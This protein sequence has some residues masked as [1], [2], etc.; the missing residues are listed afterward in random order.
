VASTFSS[1]YNVAHFVCYS[2]SNSVVVHGYLGISKF[3][4]SVRVSLLYV[5][6]NTIY[7]SFHSHNNSPSKLLIST[8]ANCF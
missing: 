8:L 4:T 3:K 2:E 5:M 7:F 1:S 6:Q